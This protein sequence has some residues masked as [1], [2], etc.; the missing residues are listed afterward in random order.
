MKRIGYKLDYSKK[1][2]QVF[3]LYEQYEGL[4]EPFKEQAVCEKGC[5]SCCIDVGSVG[6]TTLEGLIITEYLQGWDRQALKEIN[7][8]LRKNRNDKLRQVFARCA[9][10]DQEQSCRIYAVRPFS[11]RRLYSVRKCDG[12]GAVVHRQAVMLGQKIE[13][14]LQKLDPDGCSGHLS[15]ILHLL[16]KNGSRQG[17]LRENW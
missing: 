10:L 13:K 4:V 1:K 3:V 8:G 6:A 14:E 11:C 5:A 16:E 17:Y 9:F 12:Q 2:K 15:V 7:R